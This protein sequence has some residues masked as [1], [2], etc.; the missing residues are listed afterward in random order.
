MSGNVAEWCR[1]TDSYNNRD[2]KGGA[3]PNFGIK[4]KDLFIHHTNSVQPHEMSSYLGFRI[5]FQNAEPE[6]TDI[7]ENQAQSD[8]KDRL[9]E[10]IKELKTAIAEESDFDF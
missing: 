2:I 6:H 10:E 4:P 3:K 8:K 1:N 9:K 5:I 7:K